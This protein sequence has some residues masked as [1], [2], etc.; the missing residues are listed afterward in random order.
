LIEKKTLNYDEVFD[1]LV[2]GCKYLEEKLIVHRDIK[3]ANVFLKGSEWKIG[4]FGF[5]RFI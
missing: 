5:A 4:D 1:Q 3:P 2:E